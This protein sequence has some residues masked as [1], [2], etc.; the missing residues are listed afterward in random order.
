MRNGKWKM[1]G[2]GELLVRLLQMSL[3]SLFHPSAFILHPSLRDSASGGLDKL[4]QRFH[5][6]GSFDFFVDSL[7]SLGSI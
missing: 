6:A 4:D 5:F 1:T 7:K 3:L 2:E